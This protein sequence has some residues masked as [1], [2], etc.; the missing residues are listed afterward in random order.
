MHAPSLSQCPSC[1]AS[2]AGKYCAECGAPLQG[3]SC[4]ACRAPLTPG[5]KFCHRCGTPAGAQQAVA[6][7]AEPTGVGNAL[8]WAVAGIA[9]LALIALA[10]GQRFSRSAT[11]TAGSAAPSVGA[12]V[13]QRAPDISSMTPVERAERLYDRVMTLAERGRTDSVR[14]FMPMAIQ[15]YEAIGSLNA[16]QR[17]DLGRLA[18][19]GGNATV[20]AAQADTILRA[21]P[22]HLLGLLLAA[23]AANL[24][25]DRP[26]ARGYLE[27]LARAEPTE[28]AR[29]LPEYLL[30]QN[31][32]EA[33][34]NEYRQRLPR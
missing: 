24:R 6:V 13:G 14:F 7:A 32:I 16:D 29:Q 19:V 26:A 11:A 1:G 23:R 5:A 28:R 4:P 30:H 21:D 18:E 15:A 20:A 3:A 2:A 22:R 8:P 27:R 10:A 25:N 33:A 9:M 17:Y 34:L 12:A 31:D